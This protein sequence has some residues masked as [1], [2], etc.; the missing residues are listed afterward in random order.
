M[1]AIRL[2]R[3]D[4]LAEVAPEL[5]GNLTRLE[6]RGEPVLNTPEA[7]PDPYLFGAPL[8]LPANRTR[9]GRFSFEGQT[10]QLPINEPAA[11]AH[12]HGRVH[13]QRFDVA[14]RGPDAVQ[15]RLRADASVYP[16]A[17]LLTVRYQLEARGLRTDYAIANLGSGN[18]PLTFGLHTTFVEPDYFSVPLALEQER[19]ARNLPTGSYAPLSA[20][21]QAF[22]RGSDPR[23]KRISGYFSSSGPTAR[24]GNYRYTVSREFDHWILYNGGGDAGFLCVEPQCGAVNGLNLPGGCRVIAPGG[25]LRLH[26]LLERIEE[27]PE[28]E[29]RSNAE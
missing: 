26:T 29:S 6:W 27:V 8:L 3:G 13:A 21:Q 14:E 28:A 23:G 25:A 12:L 10:Y 16:F 17:F 24:I 4:W 5:G 19:D 9:D 7:A 15:L 18:M 2:A 22:V 11:P 20:A 1:K